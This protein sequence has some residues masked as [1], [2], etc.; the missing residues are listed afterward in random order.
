[1]LRWCWCLIV[2]FWSPWSTSAADLFLPFESANPQ[3]NRLQEFVAEEIVMP[4]RYMPLD[5]QR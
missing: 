2:L 5:A 1:M 3:L 4:D